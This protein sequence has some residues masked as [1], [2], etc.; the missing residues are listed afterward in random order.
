VTQEALRN[1]AKHASA[2]HVFLSLAYRDDHVLLQIEDDGR[3][4]AAP[5]SQGVQRGL[6][7]VSMGERVRLLEGTLTLMSD[8]G[9]GTRLSV[10]IP[11]TGISNEQTS[12]LT[13]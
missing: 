1:I 12:H 2:M 3:G 4:F 9:R 8:P 7:L 11:L 10:S 6:G 5:D 13:R